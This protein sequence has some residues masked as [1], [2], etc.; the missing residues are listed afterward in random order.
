MVAVLLHQEGLG[1]I[2]TI[3]HIYIV[4]AHLDIEVAQVV[5]LHNKDIMV[6]GLLHQEDLVLHH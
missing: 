3:L 4:V 2:I 1:T 5:H 6:A